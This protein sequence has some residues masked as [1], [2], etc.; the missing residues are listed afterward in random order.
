MQVLHSIS[1]FSHTTAPAELNMK[2]FVFLGDRG[3][4]CGPIAVGLPP[5]LMWDPVAVK[6]VMDE[7]MF[8]AW[9]K[10]SADA[11]L[12]WSP[13]A[14]AAYN[15]IK[16]PRALHIPRAHWTYLMEQERTPYEYYLYLVEDMARGGAPSAKVGHQFT[17]G[18]DN[19]GMPG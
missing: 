13:P 1:K 16:L 2:E 8:T 5:K 7:V 15:E 14:D 19:G 6:I 4:G 17:P 3:E 18:V 12:M 9:A 11:D 10:G